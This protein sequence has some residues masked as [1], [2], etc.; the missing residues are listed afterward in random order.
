M[1]P[2]K[3]TFAI[4]PQHQTSV[5]NTTSVAD[6]LA[7]AQS[8]ESSA[9][10]VFTAVSIEDGYRMVLDLYLSGEHQRAR[11][12]C[13]QLLAQAPDYSPARHLMMAM[14]LG[15][16]K[17]T[18]FTAA[19]LYQSAN[20]DIGDFS[21]GIP[22]V[23]FPQGS[24]AKLTIGKYCSIA[25][26]VVIYLH[27]GHRSDWFSSYPFP[28]FPLVFPSAVD[29]QGFISMEKDIVIGNDVWIG[30][31]AKIMAGVSVGNGAI[32]ATSSVVTKDVPPYTIVGGNPARF[33]RQRFD[34]E[35]VEILQKL[36]WWDLPHPVVL[37]HVHTLCSGDVAAL[38][39]MAAQLGEPARQSS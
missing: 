10:K 36:R 8:P 2:S 11:D 21:Y 23:P 15:L 14:E 31:D 28:A 27:Y 17:S 39:D 7:N 22:A 9:G 35:V 19:I 33:I 38:R 13:R 37:R 30:Q 29:I 24:K 4:Q 20:Y 34:D 26:G 16:T 1:N 12:S 25:T 6:M 3:F 32:I 5:P 18:V